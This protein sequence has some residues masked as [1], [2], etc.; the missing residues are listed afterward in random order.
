MSDADQELPSLSA[1]A[2]VARLE[3]VDGIR[4]DALVDQAECALFRAPE[5]C[6]SV[7]R[8][9][10]DAACAGLPLP[11]PV[12][13]DADLLEGEQPFTMFG[14][15]GIDRLDQ[16]VFDQAVW[17]VDRWG[18]PHRLEAM[19]ENYRHN[20]I[21]FLLDSAE[22]RWLDEV[23]RDALTAITGAWLGRVTF[24]V[25]ARRVGLSSTADVDPLTW[26]ESTPLMRRLRELTPEAPT[27]TGG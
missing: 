24:P 21:A 22:Q 15:F 9:A 3:A 13:C 26:L 4:D 8:Y 2:L 10:L 12:P 5:G 27:V 7:D 14:Q 16:R 6:R 19:S 18:C 17:W 25:L 11:S 20:V 23:R 1:S